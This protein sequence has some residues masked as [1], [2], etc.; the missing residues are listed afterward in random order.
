MQFPHFMEEEIESKR[1]KVVYVPG[2]F[3][4]DVQSGPGFSPILCAVS[5]K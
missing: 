3:V 1:S 2:H 5:Q 4:S